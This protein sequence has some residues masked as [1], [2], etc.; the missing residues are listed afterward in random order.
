MSDNKLIQVLKNLAST[1]AIADEKH[2][3]LCPECFGVFDT[4]KPNRGFYTRFRDEEAEISVCEVCGYEGD[5]P[6]MC[7]DEARELLSLYME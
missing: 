2:L 1:A 7:V 6:P 4:R 3:I 5:N